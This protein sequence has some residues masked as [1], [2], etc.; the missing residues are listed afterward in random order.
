VERVNRNLEVKWCGEPVSS[1]PTSIKGC[2]KSLTSTR[3]PS[4]RNVQYP[5]LLGYPD[6]GFPC[7][8]SCEANPRV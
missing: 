5:T 8:L 4:R 7:F 6:W 1:A 2:L 3:R